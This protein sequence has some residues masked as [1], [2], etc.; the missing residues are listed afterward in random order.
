MILK[1]QK[2]HA[3]V[4]LKNEFNKKESNEYD[5]ASVNERKLWAISKKMNIWAEKWSH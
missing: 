4:T 1:Q 2:I 3:K 5:N